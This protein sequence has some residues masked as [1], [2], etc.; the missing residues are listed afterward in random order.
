[1]GEETEII[2]QGKKRILMHPALSFRI[3]VGKYAPVFPEQT[4]NIPHEIVGVTVQLII[5]IVPALVRAEFL[6]STAAYC[7]AA[8]E[9]FPFHSTNIFP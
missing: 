3:Q 4:V 7:A 6:I 9:T 5:V 1:M 8:I 2:A